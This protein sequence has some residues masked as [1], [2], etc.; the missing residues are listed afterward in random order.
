MGT[1]VLKKKK[2]WITYVKIQISSIF[3]EETKSN[4]HHE[5]RVCILCEVNESSALWWIFVER[6]CQC[7]ACG[8]HLIKATHRY[9]Y[10][11]DTFPMYLIRMTILLNDKTHWNISNYGTAALAVH[12]VLSI[13]VNTNPGN[14]FL[15]HHQQEV[16]MNVCAFILED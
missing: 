8:E 13:F 11:T 16:T 10:K 14:R 2:K 12:N 7:L 9:M 15:L 5:Q 1:R 4:F 6:K 3:V